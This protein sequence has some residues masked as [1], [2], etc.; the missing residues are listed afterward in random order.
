MY[1][2]DEA[3]KKSI[4]YF[5]G[6]ELAAKVFVDKYALRNNNEILEDTPEKMHKRLAKEFA[7][8]ERKKYNAKSVIEEIEEFEGK[9]KYALSEKLIYELFNRFKFIIPQGSVMYGAGNNYQYITLSNC[10]LLEVPEDS[11]GS[12]LK[13][14]EQLVNI[15]KRRGGCGID[16][17]KIR[18]AGCPTKNSSRTST[19][20][21][22]FMERY[23]NSIREVGQHGRRGALMI[24]IDV[25]HPQILDFIRSKIDKTKITGA[26]ISIRLSDEFL[27]AVENKKEY[28]QR[29]PVDSKTPKISQ[30]VDANYIWDEIVKT[31]TDTAEPGIVMWGNVERTTPADCYE[32]YKSRG[33]NPCCISKDKDYFVS[34]KNGLKEIKNITNKDLI[35]INETGEWSKTS[36]YFDTKKQKVYEVVFSNGEKLEI[37]NDHKLCKIKEKRNK[38]K[39][40][41]SEGLLTELKNLKIGDRISIHT[42]DISN[43]IKFGKYGT[44]EEG[45]IM[46]WLSG[47]GCL[48]FISEKENYPNTILS[49]WK[50]EHDVADKFLKIIK[51]MKYDLNF[52]ICKKNNVKRLSSNKITHDFT[53]KYEYNI[54][55][56]KS[57]TKENMF[58]YK[59]TKDFIKGY[60]QAYF[61]ADG[62]VGLD[63]QNKNYN[64]QFS[65]INNARILQIRRILCLFG[66]KSSVGLGKK[67]GITEFKN[68]GKY[69]TKDCWR[70]TITGI[71]NLKR[72]KLHFGF[73]SKLKQDKLE[74][75]CSLSTVRKNKDS[76]FTK[77]K[78]ISYIGEKD[79]GCINVEKYNK[80][81]LNGIISGN[82]EINLSPLDSCRLLC[83]NLYSYVINPFTDQAYFDYDLFKIHAQIAQRLMDD[84]V[85]LESECIDRILSKIDSDPEDEETKRR[86]KEMWQKIKSFNN[87]G[88]R[89]GTGITALGDTIAA[90][91][92]KYGSDESIKITEKIYKTLKLSCYRSSVEMSKLL[93]PF[94]DWDAFLEKD[95]PFILRIKSEDKNLYEDMCKFGRRNISLLTTAPTGSVSTLTQTS[96]GIEPV[97][98]LSYKRRKKINPGE[99]TSKIDFTDPNGDSWQEFEVYHHKLK[100]WMRI[101]N[102]TDL[103]KSPYYGCCAEEIN[104]TNRVRLQGVAQKHI[105]H[106][107]SSTINL[108]ED[109]SYKEVKKIYEAA[110][111]EGLKGITVYRKNCRTGVLIEKNISKERP[112]E[113]E[114]DVYHLTRGGNPYF[115]LVGLING[116]PIE[117]FGGQ[118]HNDAIH[119]NVKKAKIIKRS[120]GKYKA[121]FDDGSEL[122]P[123]AAF[124]SKD[125]ESF[126]RMV[127]LCLK[128]KIKIEDL[129]IQLEKDKSGL[130][131]LAKSMS[132]SLQNYI[133]GPINIKEKCPECNNDLIFQEGCKK[134]SCG[135]SKCG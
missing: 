133:N 67:A 110:Y 95:N 90:L 129:I 135:F 31:A 36:G 132:K 96:S 93:G 28:E 27:N 60:I 102:N 9:F 115:I 24:T 46:G 58:L 71:E 81:T 114:A 5:N 19:G 134:C 12:I 100:D 14:D 43:Q 42:S 70:L 4:D 59:S 87:E 51:N 39:I 11:Y 128:N 88:R 84:L 82:S 74:K 23:S 53:K 117:I 22:P 25:H 126:A 21:I 30:M 2:Y 47:D 40:E 122:S 17:S 86:E 85:D 107:I 13:I 83:L 15:S 92:I 127:S 112:K 37:T 45:M 72:F 68:G 8:I 6:D 20:I 57:E 94:K 101:S 33:T 116:S 119:K 89:T 41:Y 18:P 78:S 34:T 63:E 111:K 38:T 109:V 124:I 62:T 52:Q 64:V 16:I 99:K 26:N 76:I 50:Q 80:F 73:L 113:V 10:Y 77:I 48:S 108:P 7:N 75:I 120:S 54:W 66:I 56:F 44:Y 125:E 103:T 98:M 123:L 55:E 131:S 1:S 32:K 130:N 97:F 29:F 61:T 91:N 104:W 69:Q 35:F 3:I 105:C 121:I 79:T 106:G 49:F 118:N 65:S